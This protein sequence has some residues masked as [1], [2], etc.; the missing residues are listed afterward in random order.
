MLTLDESVLSATPTLIK[1]RALFDNYE[2]DTTV[3]EYVTPL[4]RQEENDFLDAI[5]ATTVMKTAMRFLQ[6]KGE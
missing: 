3:N 1:L 4:E 2:M 6:S 5:L